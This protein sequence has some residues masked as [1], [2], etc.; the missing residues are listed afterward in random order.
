[1]FEKT[2]MNRKEARVGPLKNKLKQSIDMEQSN[3]KH[4]KHK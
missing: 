2:K 1:M 4:T 3:K